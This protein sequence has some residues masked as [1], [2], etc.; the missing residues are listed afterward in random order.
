M[1]LFLHI[2]LSEKTPQLDF[3]WFGWFSN[4]LPGVKYYS[5]DNH[6]E[7]VVI[8]AGLRALS[9]SEKV[10]IFIECDHS[11][12]GKTY[13]FIKQA[14]QLKNTKPLKIFC[15]GRNEKLEA[16]SKLFPDQWISKGNLEELIE[17]FFKGRT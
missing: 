7:P 1:Y 13:R 8:E 9:E 10:F 3:H 4:K 14:A 11:E 17:N 15:K 12:P 6:S 2:I 16:L 5:A